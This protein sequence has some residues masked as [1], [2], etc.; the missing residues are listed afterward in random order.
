M[1]TNNPNVPASQKAA[2]EN[3]A[4]SANVTAQQP[5][6]QPAGTQTQTGTA[7]TGVQPQGGSM[8]QPNQPARSGAPVDSSR[9]SHD[10][11]KD[12]HKDDSYKS[13]QDKKDDRN[14]S[15]Q[16]DL[17]NEQEKLDELK[18]APR[19]YFERVAEFDRVFQDQEGEDSFRRQ[20][21]YER[22][23][24]EFLAQGDP[25]RDPVAKQKAMDETVVQPG[26][27]EDA[28]KIKD[29]GSVSDK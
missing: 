19:D 8:N 21:R 13:D 9:S 5:A 18:D 14:Q 6:Q 11:N 24:D 20:A 22:E 12:H 17:K 23:R 26:A 16:K 3:S 4:P 2:A 27:V 10:Q 1:T 7:P 28:K 15:R 25:T 29:I